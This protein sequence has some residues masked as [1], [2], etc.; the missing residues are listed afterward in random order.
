MAQERTIVKKVQNA[1]LYSDGTIRIDNVRASYPHLFVPK[2]GEDGGVPK[3]SITG[4]MPKNTHE[5][6]KDLCVEVING[7]LKEKKVDR[8]PA[9]RKFIKDGDAAAKDGYDGNWSV[10][11]SEVS[12]PKLR[13]KDKSPLTKPD[14]IYGG[15]YVTILIKPWWQDN[16]FGKRVNAGLVAVQFYGPGEPFGQGRISDEEVDDSF[17]DLDDGDAGSGTD[18]DDDL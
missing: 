17:D 8:L 7:I 14:T 1:V 16:K 6:A 5:A 2:A 9:D 11:A 12:Q 15:C 4:L 18:D 10:A 13:N 3:Y